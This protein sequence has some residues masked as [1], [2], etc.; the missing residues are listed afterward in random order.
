M[1]AP[2]QEYKE[3]KPYLPRIALLMDRASG[4]PLRQHMSGMGENYEAATIEMLSGYVEKYGRPS[5]IY[6]RDSRT[7]SFIEDF[8]RK[9]GVKLIQDE[10]V[11]AIDNFFNTFSMGI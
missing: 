3:Q 10:G 4:L 6:V 7:A 9:I 11:P 5:T 8:C 1:P 2:V